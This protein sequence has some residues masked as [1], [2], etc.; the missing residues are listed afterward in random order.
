MHKENGEGEGVGEELSTRNRIVAHSVD[1]GDEAVLAQV[2][3]ETRVDWEIADQVNG[4][5]HDF[6]LRLIPHCFWLG[7]LSSIMGLV[8]IID[9]AFFSV[10]RPGEDRDCVLRLISGLGG[11]R[12]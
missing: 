1:S 6:L 3:K 9:F 10:I 5:V 8:G 7:W 11:C 12:W 4:G 2:A